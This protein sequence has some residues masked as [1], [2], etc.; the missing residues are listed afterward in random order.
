M[1]SWKITIGQVVSVPLD[2][3]KNT[4]KALD[5]MDQCSSDRSSLLVLP[6]LYLSGY[7][8]KDFISSPSGVKA[9][10][11]DITTA[12]NLIADKTKESGCDILISYPLFKSKSDKPYIALDYYSKG[13]SIATHRKMNLSNYAQYTEHLTFSEGDQVTV[14]DTPYCKAGMFICEDLWH[15]TNAIFA[16]KLGANVLFYPSAAT[17][18]ERSGAEDCLSNWKKL[19]IGTAFSQTSYVI[20]CNHAESPTAKYFGGSHIVDPNGDIVLQLPLFDEA[21]INFEIDLSYVKEIRKIRPLL[22][23]ERLEVYKKYME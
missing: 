19:T 18:I 4:D 11:K 23:N 9:F 5:L 2:I 21:V 15:I 22:D 13:K 12:L 14:A 16:A 1:K 3:K 20:C 17:V 10:K 8:I 6:E 7:E